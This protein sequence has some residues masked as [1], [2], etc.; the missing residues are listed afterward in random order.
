M[1]LSLPATSSTAPFPNGTLKCFASMNFMA[2]RDSMIQPG[3]GD[4]ASSCFGVR[5]TPWEE[6]NNL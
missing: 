4:V 3:S 5:S 6:L 1:T 2:L